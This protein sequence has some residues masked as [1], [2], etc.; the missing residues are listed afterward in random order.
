M[1]AG[2]SSSIIH[3]GGTQDAIGWAGRRTRLLALLGREGG[4]ALDDD[5]L[6]RLLDR[7][8]AREGK[9]RRAYLSQLSSLRPS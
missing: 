6:G 3:D 7:F 8:V 9:R 2:S 4:G 5:G 1:A